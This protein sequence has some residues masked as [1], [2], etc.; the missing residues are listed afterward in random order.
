VD[1]RK[2]GASFAKFDYSYNS[3]NNRTSRTETATGA[4]PE[5]DGYSYDA[6]DQVT[7][8]S[9]G[10]GRNIS[11]NYDAAG[12]RTTVND[13]GAVTPYT[14]NQLNQYT[15]IDGL[16]APGYNG[17]GSLTSYSGWIYS[18]DAQERLIAV[19]GGPNNVTATF[20]YDARNRC[21]IRTIN[22]VTTH[23]IYDG[24]RL[25][26]EYTGTTLSKRYIH[27]TMIDEI[28][29]V[30]DSSGAHYYHHDALGS[31]VALTDQLGAAVERYKYDVYG[32]IAIYDGA[33]APR[34]SS[35]W[36]NRYLFTG[37]EWLS[38]VNL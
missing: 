34:T 7:G 28:I 18:Y 2:G 19:S 21:V 32:A 22:A 24:W 25:I 27:G 33:F 29:A 8:V 16:P 5:T 4:Q 20:A 13:N 36:G 26:E 12:N 6:V 9:Y 10:S 30:I 35:A 38:E 1:H 11:Y 15:G 14:A 23:L 3:V 37:R 31:T 17:N